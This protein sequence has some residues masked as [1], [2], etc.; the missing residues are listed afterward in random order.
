M[1]VVVVGSFDTQQYCTWNEL[2][3]KAV[4]AVAAVVT[5]RVRGRLTDAAVLADE[6]VLTTRVREV[7]V[8]DGTVDGVAVRTCHLIVRLQTPVENKRR[9]VSCKHSER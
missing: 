1:I 2:I 3:A 4:V 6:A 7:D 8:S 5:D 9:S